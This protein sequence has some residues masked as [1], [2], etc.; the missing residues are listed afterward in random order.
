[1]FTLT[2]LKTTFNFDNFMFD[3]NE[4][5][6]WTM[7]EIGHCFQIMH[8]SVQINVDCIEEIFSYVIDLINIFY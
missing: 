8:D 4:L 3:S 7:L 2:F 1:M 6:N 5:T